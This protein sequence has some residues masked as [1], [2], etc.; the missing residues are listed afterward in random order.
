MGLMTLRCVSSGMQA[1]L[2]GSTYCPHARRQPGVRTAKCGD[3]MGED[4]E[5][6]E[7]R[8]STKTS[9]RPNATVQLCAQTFVPT[10]WRIYP[11]GWAGWEEFTA[12][13]IDELRESRASQN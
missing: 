7:M 5:H 6:E 8:N 12:L 3:K 4:S 9:P 2:E 13:V 10:W 1:H 11:S